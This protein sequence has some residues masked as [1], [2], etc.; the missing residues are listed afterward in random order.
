MDLIFKIAKRLGI[1]KFLRLLNLR[2]RYLTHRMAWVGR[3]SPIGRDEEKLVVAISNNLRTLDSADAIRLAVQSWSGPNLPTVASAEEL[4][5]SFSGLPVPTFSTEVRQMVLLS[6]KADI[7]DLSLR[8][9]RQHVHFIDRIVVLL[10]Q[11]IEQRCHG[12]SCAPFSA[13]YRND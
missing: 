2:C 13:R 7:L 4:A 3:L 11:G 1:G 10:E 9:V 6:V 5:G 8:S 12:C